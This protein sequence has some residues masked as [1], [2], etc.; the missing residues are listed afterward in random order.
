[1]IYF[2]EEWE[3]K[4]NNDFLVDLTEMWWFKKILSGIYKWKLS[5]PVV[6]TA[7]V[8]EPMSIIFF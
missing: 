8:G 2:N 6:K 1:M 3:P 4:N 7:G 5:G